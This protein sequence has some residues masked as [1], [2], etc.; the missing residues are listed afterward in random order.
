MQNTKM[1]LYLCTLLR[2]ACLS[3]ACMQT[4]LLPPLLHAITFTGHVLL[5]LHA[6]HT[7]KSPAVTVACY[8]TVSKCG[9]YLIMVGTVIYGW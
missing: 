2:Q 5:L 8:R 4:A 1:H 7:N 6:M 3:H 9:R